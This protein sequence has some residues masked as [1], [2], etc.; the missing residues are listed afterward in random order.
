MPLSATVATLRKKFWRASIPEIPIKGEAQDPDEAVL[1]LRVKLVQTFR[2]L[3]EDPTADP[4][5]RETLSRIIRKRRHRRTRAEMER[6]ATET[7]SLPES[8]GPRQ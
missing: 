3:D 7:D 8:E 2:L 5:L 6:A 4:T 1:D